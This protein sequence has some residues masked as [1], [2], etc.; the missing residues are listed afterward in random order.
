MPIPPQSHAQNQREE[1]LRRLSRSPHPYHRH[2]FE[3]PHA[4]ERIGG[5]AYAHAPRRRS[6][7]VSRKN[8][9]DD[10][11]DEDEH[12][13]K[14]LSSR[15]Y[16]DPTPSDSGTE[17][18]DEHFLKGLPAP[19]IRPHK[20]LRGTDGTFSASPSPLPSPAF[21]D[22][23][24]FRQIGYARANTQTGKGEAARKATDK[25]RR[26]RK[27]EI[28]RR[29]SETAILAFVGG[30]ICINSEVRQLIWLWRRGEFMI[31]ELRELR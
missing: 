28:I 23:D 22:G 6:P 11:E 5:L 31:S 3:L 17:A 16:H 18:D 2:N 29:I 9:D 7:L 14:H 20:G 26:K 30:I 15:R 24:V 21:Q 19:R 27:V 10:D 4:S 8:T 1:A 25:F 13:R 12:E